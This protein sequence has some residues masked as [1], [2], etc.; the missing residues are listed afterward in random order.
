MVRVCLLLIFFISIA[1]TSTGQKTV[2]I[3]V[4]EKGQILID[5]IIL[6]TDDLAKEVQQRLWR[7]Y[8]SNGKMVSA[9]H[10]SFDPAVTPETKSEVLYSIR[11]AQDKTLT[12]LSL[13]KHKKRFE[14]I[15]TSRQDK[16]RKQ[17]PVLFQQEYE[18]KEE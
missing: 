15:G 4:N 3:H 14:N 6:Y 13:H 7:S 17:F 9:I 11:T 10:L 2:T 12:V 5:R 1:S 18:S 8:M 16:I